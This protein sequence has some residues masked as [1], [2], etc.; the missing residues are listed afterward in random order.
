M[1][2][3][4]IN[5]FSLLILTLFL[6]FL[7]LYKKKQGMYGLKTVKMLRKSLSLMLHSIYS[8]NNKKL[9]VFLNEL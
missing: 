3:I 1:I 5:H 7:H 8:I 2:I 4:Y 6:L 9:V